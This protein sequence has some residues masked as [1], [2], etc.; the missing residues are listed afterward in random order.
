MAQTYEVPVVTDEQDTSLFKFVLED[1]RLRLLRRVDGPE[2]LLAE[3]ADLFLRDTGRQ[4][5]E[6]DRIR[7]R[8]D[9]PGP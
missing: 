4:S 2:L 7:L 9:G 6:G 1:V 5:T 8:C 3:V